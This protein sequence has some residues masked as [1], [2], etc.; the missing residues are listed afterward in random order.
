MKKDVDEK[1]FFSKLKFY[2][3]SVLLNDKHA[4]NFLKENKPCIETT[5][6][7]LLDRL[8]S[9]HDH[10][11]IQ[12]GDNWISKGFMS[13]AYSAPTNIEESEEA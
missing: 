3:S 2:W 11:V 4:E 9:K 10:F 7:V 12:M 6:R 13:I 1:S 5:V 8:G